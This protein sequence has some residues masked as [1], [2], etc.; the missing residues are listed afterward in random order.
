MTCSKSYNATMW[1][2]TRVKVLAGAKDLTRIM[3]LQIS[4]TPS[5]VCM[6]DVQHEG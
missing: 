6:Q 5:H 2:P 1:N 3:V 4:R